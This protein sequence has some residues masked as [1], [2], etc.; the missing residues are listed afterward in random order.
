MNGLSAEEILSRRHWL[1][2]YGRR[3]PPEINPD[4]HGSVLDMLEAAMQRYAEKPAFRCFG[5]TLT[6]AD[7]DGLSRKV[8]GYLQGNSVSGRATASR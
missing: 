3:I 8:A 7:T 5:R 4:A 6:Y 2:A 1:A